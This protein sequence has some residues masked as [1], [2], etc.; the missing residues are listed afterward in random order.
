[1]DS[2]SSVA[3]VAAKTEGREADEAL[4]ARPLIMLVEDD[5]VLRSSLAE[6]LR[7]DGY[8]VESYANGFD[9]LKRLEVRPLPDLILLDIM[10]PYMDGVAFRERQLASAASNIPVIVITAVG[11]PKDRAAELRFERTFWKPLRITALLDA[12]HDLCPREPS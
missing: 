12:I 8:R 5:F 2:E 3:G 10:L 4:M 1:M 7:N 11:V 6:L 9:A